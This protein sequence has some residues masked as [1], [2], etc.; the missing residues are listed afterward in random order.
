MHLASG[1]SPV[2]RGKCSVIWS[3][4]I[5]LWSAIAVSAMLATDGIHVKR[6]KAEM[7]WIPYEIRSYFTAIM[8]LQAFVGAL[9]LGDQP[10]NGDELRFTPH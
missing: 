1:G 4:L 3:P 2:E 10:A 7:I 8:K 9:E 5:V 6:R